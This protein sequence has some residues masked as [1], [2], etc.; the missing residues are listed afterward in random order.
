MTERVRLA[1]LI[2]LCCAPAL[3]QVTPSVGPVDTGFTSFGSGKVGEQDIFVFDLLLDI[4]PSDDWVSEG[5]EVRP[6]PGVKLVYFFSQDPNGNDLPYAGPGTAVPDRFGTFLS[7]P[8]PA[9][10]NGRF[11]ADYADTVAGGFSPPSP[12]PTKDPNEFDV[13]WFDS[14][15]GPTGVRAV[16]R[17]ALDVSALGLTLDGIGDVVFVPSPN[18]G[19]DPFANT[20]QPPNTQLV[21]T[22]GSDTGVL[23][24]GANLVPY[25]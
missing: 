1:W 21:A 22:F 4:D 6:V 23:S 14:A 5:A 12:T 13:V 25:N 19:A 8:R 7:T 15:F 3:A 10:A 11:N 20:V 24:L 17:I 18:N 9:E 16:L 2:G